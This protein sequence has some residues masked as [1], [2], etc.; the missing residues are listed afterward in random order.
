M[1][2]AA[3]ARPHERRV[4]AALGPF[5]YLASLF[6]LALL[7]WS[8]SRVLLT[9]ALYERVR[10]EPRH[11]LVFPLGLRMDSVTASYLLV[12]PTLLLF[13]L[14]GAFLRRLRRVLAAYFAL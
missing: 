11:G 8:L 6:L 13:T 1:D 3:A 9:L 10:V 5:A 2:S 12:P 14:P 4:L 7:V